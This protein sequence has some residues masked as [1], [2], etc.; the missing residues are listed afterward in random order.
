MSVNTILVIVGAVLIVVGLAKAGQSGGFNLRNF[1]INFGGTTTQ[2]NKIGN[3]TTQ[4][5]KS[6][7]P[8]WVGLAIA[9]IGLVSAVIG[10]LKG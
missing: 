2:T 9:A 5:A 3:V 8:D 7:K 1:G 10:L 6:A 4:S